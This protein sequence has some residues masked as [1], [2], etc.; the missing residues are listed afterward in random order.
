MY[1]LEITEEEFEN[2]LRQ[3]EEDEG[4]FIQNEA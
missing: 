1:E 2:H 4:T 3:A